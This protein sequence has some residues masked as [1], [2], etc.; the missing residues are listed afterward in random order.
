[1]S[2]ENDRNG[3][4]KRFKS[5]VS[6]KPKRVHESPPALRPSSTPSSET[7]G[8]NTGGTITTRPEGNSS[9]EIYSKKS[10]DT[11]PA[12][13]SRSSPHKT[14]FKIINEPEFSSHSLQPAIPSRVRCRLIIN[15]DGEKHSPSSELE[16]EWLDSQSYQKLTQ[17]RD[18]GVSEA[19]RSRDPKVRSASYINGD[20]T[21][22]ES[23]DGSHD[24]KEI[25]H[26][27]LLQEHDWNETMPVM[28]AKF[29]AAH[30][31][32]PFYLEVN[33]YFS[34]VLETTSDKHDLIARM[35]KAMSCNWETEGHYLP[36]S[37]LEKLFSKD[38]VREL[39]YGDESLSKSLGPSIKKSK[40][41]MVEKVL[42]FAQRLFAVCVWI[43]RPLILLKLLLDKGLTDTDLPLESHDRPEFLMETHFEHIA[44]VQGRFCVLDFFDNGPDGDKFYPVPHNMTVPISFR[45]PEDKLGEGA[46]GQ[47]F[48]A[49]IHS[50]HH[51]FPSVSLRQILK[52]HVLNSPGD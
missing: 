9:I 44:K 15:L 33:F 46:F 5:L 17:A 36:R 28:V 23:I 12:T 25:D 14:S 1:M 31:Y 22:F 4:R 49:Q 13:G 6:K 8:H 51:R 39:I 52:Q 40:D 37:E 3:F 18:S 30:P 29:A 35:S 24:D 45:D 47:V 34:S 10:K 32:T 41:E 7:K 19:A 42:L 26:G 27:L 48:R 38:Q 16:V 11:T 21:L 2:Q 50:D 20:I 43:D